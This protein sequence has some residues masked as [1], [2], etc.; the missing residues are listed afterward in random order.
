MEKVL[1]A[2]TLKD[3]ND[4][5]TSWANGRI[6]ALKK[7]FDENRWNGTIEGLELMTESASTKDEE[8][9]DADGV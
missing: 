7:A 4:Y 8:N 6:S 1:R 5:A 3:A 9:G 2:N